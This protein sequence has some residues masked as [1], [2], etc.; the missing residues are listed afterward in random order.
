MVELNDI[1]FIIAVFI[2]G[3]FVLEFGADK[4][5]DNTAIIAA[6]LNVSPTLIAL[7]TSV[8]LEKVTRVTILVIAAISQH[9]SSLA[10]GNIVESSIST[11]RGAFPL[12]LIF[13]RL[14]LRL[15]RAQRSIPSFLSLPLLFSP[16]F[17]FSSNQGGGMV[18]ATLIADFVING[19]SI[20]D[21]IYKGIISAPEDDSDGGSDTS[22]DEK[23]FD[24]SVFV[25]FRFPM[26]PGST[27][28]QAKPQT[29]DEY[30]NLAPRESVEEH[31]KEIG[32]KNT[33]ITSL[34]TSL[35]LS[36]TVI[37]T[38]TLSIATTLSENLAVVLSGEK[39]QGGIILENKVGS[40]IFLL[41][42]CASIC[43]SPR[44]DYE[45]AGY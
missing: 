36:T 24:E 8:A 6:R 3:L 23:G 14:L 42:L 37:G 30:E 15:I 40:N 31:N 17:P 25:K 9:Q 32:Q 27:R 34:T 19:I 45:R 18:G 43:F 38:I 5:I 1:A 39:R 4:F 11:I 29:L 2:S 16:H 20:I 13:L 22:L 35:S 44:V 7:L 41:T 10:I 21:A 28:L 12:G 26:R 33:S